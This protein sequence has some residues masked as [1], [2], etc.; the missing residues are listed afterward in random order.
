[1]QLQTLLS[2]ARAFREERDWKQYH[3]ARNVALSVVLEAAELLE[4]FQWK[5]DKESEEIT[6]DPAAR[7]KISDELADIL[8]YIMLMA[9]DLDIDLVKAAEEKIKKNAKK[10]PVHKSKGK[11]LKYTEL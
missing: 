9:D 7:Q 5:T 6:K 4:I 2:K 10:Y 3:S 1:M 8:L 11:A